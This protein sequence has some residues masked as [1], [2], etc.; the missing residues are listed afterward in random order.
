MTLKEMK[1]I[2]RHISTIVLFLFVIVVVLG[3]YAPMYAYQEGLQIFMFNGEFFADT[4]LRPGGLSDYIGCF[5]VQFFMYPYW[6]A[7][8]IALLAVGI[9]LI[10]RGVFVDNG[11]NE[12]SADV[13]GVVC[14]LGVVATVLN[15]NVMFGGCVAVLIAV[16]AVGLISGKN[17]KILLGIITPLIY[18][19]TGG[20]C[21]LIYIAALTVKSLSKKD[22]LFPA[23]NIG[24]LAFCWLITKNIMQDDSLYGTFT[25]V[26]FNRYTSK[27]CDVWYV[28]I[29]I[30]IISIILSKI[31]INLAKKLVR[32]PLYAAAIA[33]IIFYMSTNY[34]AGNMLDYKIDR[35]VRYKQ[36]GSI[37][38][39]VDKAQQKKFST[40]MSQCYLN[41][42]LCERNLL[43]SKMFNFVQVGKE[44]LISSTIN[45][46]DKSICNSEIYFR[47]GLLNISERLSME[48]MEGNDTSQKSARM[49]KR[50]AECAL[51]KGQKEL[52]MRYIKKLQATIY[53]RAWA[54]RAEQ[55][56]NDPAHTEAL[57][58]WKI[59]PIEMKHD[60]FFVPAAGSEFLYSLFTN[61]ISN[62][63]LFRYL[64]G[65]LL[66][67]K[68]IKRLYGFLATS[69]P[70]GELGTHIYEGILLYLFLNNKD[71]F[72]KV[73]SS[74]NALTQKFNEFGRFLASNEAKNPQRAK[75]LFGNTYWFYYYF[76]N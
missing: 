35:M 38:E 60:Q 29:A 50:L 34:D 28:A 11:S 39:E 17:N 2:T 59:K 12:Q 68:D 36:W 18:W 72:N 23:I 43:D 63:K 33:G 5:F 40:Y 61:N 64:L 30:I 6:T 26:D 62:P 49:Y 75:E 53:Y 45:S 69:R 48:A 20:W 7:L 32:F 56:L 25:G 21:C 41:L 22:F 54:L 47:L 3:F 65:H 1:N 14:A 19:L 76:C 74:N 71:E 58:D 9:Q 27:S 73:M 16:A 15:F 4:C 37:I 67:E 57:A 42:A 10:L 51:L 70:D 55:Y 66:L 52:A 13:L 44:G 8:I 24:V 31:K 46:Q